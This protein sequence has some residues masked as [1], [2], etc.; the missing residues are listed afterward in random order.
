MT[1]ATGLLTLAESL[2][3]AD[4]FIRLL[5]E[6]ERRI[7]EHD[8]ALLEAKARGAWPVCGEHRAVLRV[9]RELRES[10]AV[11]AMHSAQGEPR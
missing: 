9:L 2:P 1:P 6:I 10:A 7:R 8:V 11:M 3:S 5:P 4:P